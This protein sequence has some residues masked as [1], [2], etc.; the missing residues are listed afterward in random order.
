MDT[1]ESLALE[2]EELKGEL[3]QVREFLNEQFDAGSCE[4]CGQILIRK[5][6]LAPY[7]LDRGGDGKPLRQSSRWFCGYCVYAACVIMGGNQPEVRERIGEWLARGYG[8]AF[9]AETDSHFAHLGPEP[10]TRWLRSICG[11]SSRRRGRER[12]RRTTSCCGNPA[13]VTDWRVCGAT[14]AA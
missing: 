10:I 7:G 11:A 14:T 8:R 13:A 3:S 4:H 1:V 5:H 12:G 6:M 9:L 2:I